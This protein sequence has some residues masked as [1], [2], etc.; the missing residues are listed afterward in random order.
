M[1][2]WDCQFDNPDVDLPCRGRASERPNRI[3]VSCEMTRYLI[4][5]DDTD[6]KEKD[7]SPG[8]TALVRRLAEWLRIDGAAEA[9]GITRHQLFVNK[10]I[11][12]TAHN[13][14]VCLSFDA[15]DMEAVWETT[16]DFLV[17]GS[18]RRSNAGMCLSDWDSVGPD[19]MTWGH[20]AKTEI[21]TQEEAL[22]VAARTGVRCT[23]LK[24]SGGGVIGALAAIG[25]HR[26]GSDGRFVWL[27]G[28]LE[29]HGRYTVA[30][31]FARTAIDRVSS[32]AEVDL[33]IQELVE[34]AEW[35]RPV[36]RNGQATLFV[37]ETKHGWSVVDKDRVKDL[38]S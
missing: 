5:I 18:H 36:L 4:G 24:G 1:G 32:L 26:E 22:R 6:T 3:L 16:R 17:L 10:R 7:Q 31:I 23:G 25:L 8:T 9:K 12:Y 37:E 38:S 14:S 13:S 33:P 11:A 19:V 21:L 29:L 34:V 27:P 2:L 20:R 15:T 30:E 35:T 28:L